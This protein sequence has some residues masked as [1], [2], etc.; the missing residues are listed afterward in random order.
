M[1]RA[2]EGLG[3]RGFDDG[4]ARGLAMTIDETVVFAVE[5]RLPP[6]PQRVK[7]AIKTPLTKREL[8]IA[9]LVEAEM[10]SREIATKLFISER[11]V[12]THVTNI[13]NKLGLNSRSQLS[14]WLATESPTSQFKERTS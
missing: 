14:R 13:F 11:T 6:P 9:R 12:E 1:T 7:T 8:E 4:Y 10:S 2:L 3:Q 5:E